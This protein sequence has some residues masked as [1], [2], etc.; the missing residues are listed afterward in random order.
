MIVTIIA[1][2]A[3]VS[4]FSLRELNIYPS[5]VSIIGKRGASGVGLQQ[6][7]DVPLSGG[8]NRLD[9]LHYRTL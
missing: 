6:V 8:A 1:V 2:L 9:Y 3:V 7:K 4:L 5:L